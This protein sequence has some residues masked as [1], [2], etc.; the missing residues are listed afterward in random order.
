MTD[1]E[2]YEGDA[3]YTDLVDLLE[4]AKVTKSLYERINNSLDPY[5]P[6]NELQRGEI[7]CLL[8]TY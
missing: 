1:Y 8:Y 5:V 2:K 7:P 3:V 6:G 4:E